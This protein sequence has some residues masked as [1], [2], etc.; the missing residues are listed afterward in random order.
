MIDGKFIGV[1]NVNTFE[2]RKKI[3]TPRVEKATISCVALGL[4]FIEINGKRVGEGYLMPGWTDYDNFVQLARFDVTE[5]LTDGENEIVITVNEGWYKG[6][7]SWSRVVDHYGEVCAVCA[8]INVGGT[9]I[10]TDLHWKA[11]TSHIVSS[12]IY[13]GETVDLTVPKKQLELAEVPFDKNKIIER[14]CPFV[15]TTETLKPVSVWECENGFLYDFGQNFAGVV[16]LE[17]PQSFRGTAVMRYGEVL[18]DGKLYVGNLGSAKATDS[19]VCDRG[20]TFCPEF[21]YHGFRYMEVSGINAPVTAVGCVRHTPMTR[22]GSIVTSNARLNKLIANIVWGQRSNFV[23]IPTDCPQ[24]AERL[25]WTGDINVFCATAAFNYDIRKFMRKWLNDVRAEQDES[26]QI[27]M[28]VP[29]VKNNELKEKISSA[30]WSDVLVSA[31]Y[32]LYK[33]YGETSFIEDNYSAMKKL[34]DC[35][36][37]RAHGGLI[38]DGFEFGDWLALDGDGLKQGNAEGGTDKYFIA[39]AF[40]AHALDIICEC[41]KISG[42]TDDVSRYVE[43]RKKL[44]SAMRKEYFTKTGRFFSDKLTAQVLALCFNIVPKKYRSRLAA[45]LNENVKAYGYRVVTGFAGTPYLPFA[46]SD[47][48]YHDAACKVLLNNGYPGWLY[49]ADM[50][51]TTV[52]ERWNSLM[53]DG[54]PNPDGMNSYNHY[55]YGSV[56]EFVYRRIVGLEP[57]KNGFCTFRFAPRPCKGIARI[58][59][60]YQTDKGTIKAGYRYG[61]GKITYYVSVPKGCV[62]HISLPNT[63]DRTVKSDF[64]CSCNCENLDVFP[65]R[66]DSMFFEIFGNPKANKAFRSVFELHPMIYSY[67]ENGRENVAFLRDYLSKKGM[68]TGEQ[69]D[70]KFDEFNRR[71][72]KNT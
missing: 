31:P 27:P 42:K 10:T 39:N 6:P 34:V 3:S 40:L 60:E 36:I 14:I 44:V 38:T 28:V 5:Y 29:H 55:A 66:S 62:A 26:G 16:K 41:A 24:R 64:E 50:G 46:L 48:G 11:Y 15:E 30:V 9:V 33:M 19:F 35:R 67:L 13:D 45:E 47:N 22:T 51:A 20:G 52:W 57:I 37:K 43:E 69:F 4:F 56:M 63:A 7:L 54:T 72:I 18:Q 12:G 68:M 2:V 61:N 21:T 25:G 8:E 32:T 70:I 58:H 71:F 53:P 23:D 17:F 59:A 65:F 1:H 49:E